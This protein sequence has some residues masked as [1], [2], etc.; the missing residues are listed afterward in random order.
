MKIS[1]FALILLLCLNVSA[2]QV[3]LG[4]YVVPASPH[5]LKNAN[6]SYGLKIDSVVP[7]SPAAIGGLQANDIIFKIDS[8]NI[9]SEND[10]QKFL[11]QCTPQSVLKISIARNK[12]IETKDII[13]ADRNDLHKELYIYNY[14]QNPWLFIGMNVE[15]IS[16]A[17]AHLLRLETG[18]LILEIRENS[19]AESQGL[20]AGDIIIS[21]NNLQTINEHALTRALNIGLQNQPMNFFIWR[22]SEKFNLPISLSNKKIDNDTENADEIF[23][24]GPDIY[25]SELYSYS[26]EKINILLNKPKSE[27]EE[28]IERLENEI[29]KLRQ[30]IGNR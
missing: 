27:L 21:V 10:L 8:S 30:K 15:P 11:T 12:K 18:V 25:D 1:I 5:D 7:D 6:L 22:N 14:I 19:I 3:Y 13:L 28:D 20:E 17:L 23:I 9:R 24:V 2:Q 29:F 16:Q 26:K 4:I